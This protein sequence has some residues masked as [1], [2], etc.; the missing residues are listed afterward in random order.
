[1]TCLPSVNTIFTI[2]LF[3]LRTWMCEKMVLFCVW[4][5][6]IYTC[7]FEE[8]CKPISL[9]PTYY[10]KNIFLWI[11]ESKIDQTH[12]CIENYKEIFSFAC[13]VGSCCWVCGWF[14]WNCEQ[15]TGHYLI[16]DCLVVFEFL[17]FMQWAFLTAS[18]GLPLCCVKGKDIFFFFFHFFSMINMSRFFYL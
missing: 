10:K 12:E 14:M 3:F 1:M 15:N 2:A 6:T 7:M 18:F 17:I 13:R 11:Y 5:C 8:A 4:Q 16:G 9:S